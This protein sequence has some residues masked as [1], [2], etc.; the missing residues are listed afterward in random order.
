MSQQLDELEHRLDDAL[1]EVE[2]D[3]EHRRRALHVAHNKASRL[4]DLR[5]DVLIPSIRTRDNNRHR[6]VSVRDELEDIRVDGVSE[7]EKHRH[8]VLRDRLEILVDENEDLTATI[9]RVLPRAHDLAK[10]RADA[11]RMFKHWS[12]ELRLAQARREK[13][14]RQIR[15][16]HADIDSNPL[17]TPY[18][19]VAEF[20]CHNGV[21]VPVASIPALRDHVH[22]YLLPLRAAYGTVHINSGFR[23]YLYNISIGGASLSVHVY[24]ASWQESPWAV[25]VDHIAAGANPSIVQNWHEIHTHPDG[26][27]RYSSFTHCDNRNRIGWADSRWFG[28]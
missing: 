11:A 1:E 27:G 15:Q 13:I 6:L 14:Q 26:M 21:P 20:D 25:A 9:R 4:E 12:E 10:G 18:F 5:D 19:V 7:D 8:G 28:P 23:T 24:N 2:H 3:R 22:R 17:G 16:A